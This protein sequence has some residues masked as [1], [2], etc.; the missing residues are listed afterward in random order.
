MKVKVITGADARKGLNEGVDEIAN[1]VKV[2]LGPKGR[3]VIIDK[4][5]TVPVITKDGVTVAEAIEVEGD[6]QNM[7]VRIIKQ[8]AQR[9]ADE[10]GDGTTTATVLAQA[11]M[12]EAN[13]V[14]EDDKVNPI[15]LQRGMDK[16]VKV[17]VAKLKDYAIEVT[18][19]S[20][21]VE[22][23]AKIS[24][25]ND[26]TIG[27]MIVEALR[28]V[29]ND[30]V[31]AVE[32]SMKPQSSVEVVEGLEFNRGLSNNTYITDNSKM[33]ADMK[34]PY[35]FITDQNISTF[36]Q[37][38]ANLLDKT[39]QQERPVIFI[40]PDFGDQVT[41]TLVV[42]K[43]KGILKVAAIRAPGM[44]SEREEILKDI[45]ILTGGKVISRKETG[46]AL[47]EIE[48]FDLEWLGSCDRLTSDMKNTTIIG[49]HGQGDDINER[50]DQIKVQIGL[51]EGTLEKTK[52]HERLAKIAGG[53][54]IIKVGGVSET[55]IKEKKDRVDDAL[56]A[57]KAALA[58]GIVPGGGA[59]LLKIANSINLND[60]D[61]DTKDE[62]RGAQ[63]LLDVCKVPFTTI[64]D[65][66]GDDVDKIT[67]RLL[68]D[69]DFNTVYDAKNGA[70]CDAVE[71]GIVA[72]A[73]VT[74]VALESAVGIVGVF[75]TTEAALVII[76]DAAADV[77]A[78]ASNPFMQ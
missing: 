14:L 73:K 61:F 17:I 30:G 27:G 53:V 45:A 49:G 56:A 26:A 46:V 54:A 21:S 4:P 35:I 40:A 65:N 66:S 60:S 36:T 64:L 71:H 20:D 22:H 25:N 31:I 6:I 47:N 19:D 55:A 75:I 50:V 29:E 24:A 5:N 59:A 2:T 62:I 70:I 41:A 63:I 16:L 67:K 8:V 74:R 11:I 12:K 37:P 48:E 1:A 23:V 13:N 9:T 52:L 18:K 32:E 57:T 39:N 77:K 10:A 69:K 38:L 51:A 58:E 43:M 68:K 42:N 44:G 15:E 72:P 76:P 3:N 7:A 33:R 28:A 78:A 34:E